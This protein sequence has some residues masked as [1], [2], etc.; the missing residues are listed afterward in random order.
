MLVIY[1]NY[2]EM[3]HGQQNIKWV[4]VTEQYHYDW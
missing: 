2:A 4:Y 3:Q 1:Q